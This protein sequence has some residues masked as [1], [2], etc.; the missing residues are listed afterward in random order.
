MSEKIIL[1][2][3]SVKFSQIPLFKVHKIRNCI[4]WR[5]L[6]PFENS[7]FPFVVPFE[8][9]LLLSKIMLILILILMQKMIQI[10]YTTY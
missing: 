3:Q 9:K 7:Y 10:S 6:F 5:I 1:Q 2:G 8:T 4:V